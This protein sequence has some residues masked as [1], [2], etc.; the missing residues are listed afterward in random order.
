MKKSDI[1]WQTYLMLEKELIDVSKYIYVTDEISINNKIQP[2]TTQLET[3]SPHIADLIIRA[4]I[5]IEAISKELYF[6]FGG[7]KQRGDTNLFFDEDCLKLVD[8][9][10]QTHKKIVLIVSPLFSLTKE[11]NKIFKPLKDAHKRKGTNWERAYQALKHD[12]Y[13]SIHYGTIK[14]LIHALGALYLLNIYYKDIKLHSKYLEYNHLD[15][16]LGSSIFSVQSPKQDY[17]TAAINGIEIGEKLIADESP[18]VLKYTD[19]VYEELIELNKKS[20]QEKREYLLSQPELRDPI[21]LNIIEDELARKKENSHERFIL[22]WELC[23]YR[24]NKNIPASLPF[25]E[26]KKRFVNSR[27]W[28][29]IIRMNNPHLSEEQLTP[30]NIQAEIDNAGVLAGM[31]IEERFMTVKMQKALYEGACELVL[32]KGNIKYKN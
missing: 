10:C 29:G 19:K 28:N 8:E 16:S 20:L 9:M 11:K 15:L 12:R 26:R 30:Q 4:C 23:K 5:E 22:S 3:F 6:D 21:F 14:N 7:E 1:F 17:I 24:I 32:D 2:C 31:E 18:F 27:E 25:D 13:S